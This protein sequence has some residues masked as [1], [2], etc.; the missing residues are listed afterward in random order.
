MPNAYDTFLLPVSD[1]DFATAYDTVDASLRAR[2][3]TTIAW[4][5]SMFGT[6]PSLSMTHTERATSGFSMGHVRRPVAWAVIV[7]TEV[8]ASGPRLLAALMPALLAG[9]PVHVVR[10]VEDT[11]ECR[12]WPAVLLAALELAGQELVAVA[13]VDDAVTYLQAKGGQG[14]MSQGR[15]L[16]LGDDVKVKSRLAHAVA[17]MPHVRF[18]SEGRAPHIFIDAEESDRAANEECI[19]WAHPDCTISETFTES[20]NAVYTTRDT[21]LY[22]GT[23]TWQ[24]SSCTLVLERACEALWLYTDLRPEFFMQST[25]S[26]GLLSGT[27]VASLK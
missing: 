11:E 14:N 17:N 7:V 23:E 2:L 5:H 10:I 12:P 25:M 24:S 3:K 9:I 6:S 1:D 26:I 19:R 15:V 16:F 22:A 20:V 27:S 8:F 21:A 4:H 18:W 13:G